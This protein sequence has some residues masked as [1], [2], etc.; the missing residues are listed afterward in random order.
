MK[1]YRRIGP[2]HV[3]TILVVGAMERA[4]SSQYHLFNGTA[5]LVSPFT[6]SRHTLSLSTV[7]DGSSVAI[8][9]ACFAS[10]GIGLQARILRST[11]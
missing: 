8:V 10:Q 6:N 5:R 7:P 1:E 4:G 3:K 2:D 11:A 9:S